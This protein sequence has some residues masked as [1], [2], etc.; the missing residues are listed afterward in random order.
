MTKAPPASPATDGST[1]MID[2]PAFALPLK[3]TGTGP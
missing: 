1:G 3:F 2:R